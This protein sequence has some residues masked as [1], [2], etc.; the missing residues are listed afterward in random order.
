MG[1]SKANEK[2]EAAKNNKEQ[3]E[4]YMTGWH[5]ENKQGMCP[6]PTQKFWIPF[7]G[8]VKTWG[9]PLLLEG[10]LAQRELR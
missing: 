6:R 7:P 3:V 9:Q 4:S 1:I 5:L 10:T 8:F 2:T